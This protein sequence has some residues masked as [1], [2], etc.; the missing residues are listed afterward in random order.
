[1]A[2]KLQELFE[3]DTENVLL[4]V[5]KKVQTDNA[6]YSKN[7][8]PDAQIITMEQPTGKKLEDFLISY[9]ERNDSVI[10]HEGMKRL[11][12]ITESDFDQIVTES[13]KLSLLM[14]SVDAD[15]VNAE[16]Y[17]RKGE[18]IFA[19]IESIFKNDIAK[20]NY[21]MDRMKEQDV[22]PFMIIQM[23]IN[24]TFLMLQIKN[25]LENHTI[26]EVKSQMN[27]NPFRFSKLAGTSEKIGKE[28]LLKLFDM[29]ID[30]EIKIKKNGPA[31]VYEILRA[32]L[33]SI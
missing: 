7:I 11:I 23:V 3:V 17:N 10:T 29:M 8:K 2:I 25:L 26:N 30:L 31:D 16:V 20:I 32:K 24:D 6:F 18:S 15:V 13:E 5:S 21:H 1:M 28:K 9:F 33:I 4:L 27:L 22:Q 14:E 19:V 12:E